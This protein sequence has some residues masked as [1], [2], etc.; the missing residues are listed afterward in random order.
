MVKNIVT[1]L[2]KHSSAKIECFK[3][4]ER[5]D[6]KVYHLFINGHIIHLA[7]GFDSYEEPHWQVSTSYVLVGNIPEDTS[8]RTMCSIIAEVYNITGMIF[9]SIKGIE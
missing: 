6:Y 4:I 7:Q 1:Y 3:V 2:R 5:E 9:R 8:I